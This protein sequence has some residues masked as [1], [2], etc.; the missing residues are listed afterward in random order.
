MLSTSARA[1]AVVLLVRLLCVVSATSYIS[2]F[3]DA[4][5]TQLLNEWDGP[6]G[7]PNGSCTSIRTKA[8]GQVESFM[9]TAT[10]YTSDGEDMCSENAITFLADVQTC[11]N[12][13]WVYYSI[14]S[15]TPG[16]TSYTRPSSSDSGDNS[17]LIGAIVGGV[18]GGVTLLALILLVPL[19]FCFIRPRRK[20]LREQKAA[21]QAYEL[22]LQ[23]Q[24][25]SPNQSKEP[26]AFHIPAELGP[27]Q[28][29]HELPETTKSHPVELSGPFDR[30]MS[31]EEKGLHMR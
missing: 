30:N 11:Y 5:C 2:S 16:G 13:S 26:S 29:K 28:P 25:T 9:I 1:C 22:Q 18:I 14:D 15:C 12:S 19:F 4:A 27:G 20:L 24:Q 6:N 7:Y 23:Q 8:Q 21:L 17:T 3:S 31:D 10:L